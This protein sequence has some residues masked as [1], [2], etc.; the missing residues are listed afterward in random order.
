[1]ERAFIK[2]TTINSTTAVAYV[3]LIYNPSPEIAYMC[4]DN[5]R[6][7]EKIFDTTSATVPAVNINAADS[8]TIRPMPRITPESIPGVA[9]GKT[10]EKIV[11]N[12]PA[13]SPKLPSR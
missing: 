4:T 5:V 12:F 10:I 2:I 11:R 13:P 8:P 7:E 1:M 3:W 9:H 6:A